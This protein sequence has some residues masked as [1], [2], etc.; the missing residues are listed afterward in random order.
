MLEKKAKYVLRSSKSEVGQSP[1]LI[2]III[3]KMYFVYL[4]RSLQDSSKTYVGYTTNLDQRLETHN[5]GGSLHTKQHRPWGLVMYLAFN[6]EDK[7]KAFEKYIKVGS[8]YAF[9]KKRLW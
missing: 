2:W 6:S 3:K 9:A 4:L 5:A 1:K 8:G 7:A